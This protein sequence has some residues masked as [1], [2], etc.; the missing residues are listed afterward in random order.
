MPVVAVDGRPFERGPAAAALQA[1]LRA[2]A[3]A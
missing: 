3:A 1:A 2:A